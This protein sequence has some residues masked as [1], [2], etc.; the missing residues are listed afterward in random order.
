MVIPELAWLAGL[1]MLAAAVVLF[2]AE[3]ESTAQTADR[4]EEILN[5]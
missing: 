1:F 2:L 3:D 4:Q 5:E